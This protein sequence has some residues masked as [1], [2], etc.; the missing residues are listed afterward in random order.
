MQP[1]SKPPLPTPHIN[2]LG[3]PVICQYAY[4]QTVLADFPSEANMQM[5]FML[6]TI[7][8][9]LMKILESVL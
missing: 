5:H 4:W 2:I 8:K 3:V 6:E 7:F 9:F 1:D